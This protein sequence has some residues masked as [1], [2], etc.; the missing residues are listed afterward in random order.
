[1]NLP[2][3]EDFWTLLYEGEHRFTE[4]VFAGRWYGKVY[5]KGRPRLGR[6][7]KVFTP[8][9]TAKFEAAVKDWYMGQ[10][11]GMIN[12][13]VKVVITLFDPIPKSAPK[14]K[15]ALM[16]LN[17]IFSTNGDVDNRAKSIL[18]AANEAMLVDDALVNSLT[19][20]RHYDTSEGFHISIYRNGL[21]VSYVD[22]LKET[23]YDNPYG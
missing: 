9:N 18:D 12:Y 5:S 11:I 6:R 19:V 16:T 15:K 7:N 4:K 14:W 17:A 13:P 3:P 20:T 21:P 10:D 8:P 22:K 1:M 2:D 23:Y